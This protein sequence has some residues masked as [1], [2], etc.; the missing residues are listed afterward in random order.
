M[1]AGWPFGLNCD[2]A[3]WEKKKKKK[4]KRKRIS[5][6]DVRGVHALPLLY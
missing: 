3:T 5:K 2:V 6:H 4:E 1:C